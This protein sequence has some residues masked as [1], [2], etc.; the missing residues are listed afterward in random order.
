MA[1]TIG[2]LILTA[3]AAETAF[4]AATAA[5][6]TIIGTGV[7]VGGSYAINL[8]MQP[9]AEE[10]SPSDGQITTKQPVPPRR[11][12]YGRV[13]VGGPLMFVEPAVGFGGPPTLCQITALNSGLIDAFEEIWLN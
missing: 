2:M 4:G 6:A 12:H 3:V 7:L 13:K 8:A 9:D 10:K 1:E 11:R 5:V